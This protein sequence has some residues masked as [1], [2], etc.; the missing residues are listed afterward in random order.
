MS[1]IKLIQ[2]YIEII[3]DKKITNINNVLIHILMSNK[4]RDLIQTMI[5]NLVNKKL[6][7]KKK[8]VVGIKAENRK[9]KKVAAV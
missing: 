4:T 8:K 3:L 5:A 2:I 9:Y 7:Q 1:M 6:I